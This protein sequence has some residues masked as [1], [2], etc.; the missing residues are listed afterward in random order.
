M[1]LHESRTITVK[2]QMF[3]LSA[4]RGSYPKPELTW[5][6][7]P[8]SSV[9]FKNTTTVQKTEQQL[10]NING[11]L[12]LSDSGTD[13]TYSCTVSSSEHRRT[14]TLFKQ[15]NKTSA[16]ETTI[17]CPSSKAPPTVFIWRFNHSQI[18]V[19]QTGANVPYKVSEEWRQQVKA[20]SESGSLTL[21]AL[22]PEQQGTYTCEF[23]NEEETNV[24]SIFLKI[25]ESK[26][27]DINAAG[28]V[29][30][31]FGLIGIIVVAAATFCKRKYIYKKCIKTGRSSSDNKTGSTARDGEGSKMIPN[32][33]TANSSGEDKV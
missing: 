32:G 4:Q 10:Y 25:E 21:T 13:V 27:P 14:A 28:I 22:T 15:L 8:P 19:T 16:A 6:T 1:A 5:S 26:D 33:T 3:H 17:N 31:V 2:D 11:S 18:I 20:V 29:G 24:E 12:I 7:S 23:R 30:G 9:T